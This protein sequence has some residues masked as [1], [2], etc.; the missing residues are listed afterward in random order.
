[1]VRSTSRNHSSRSC[2]SR[3]LRK[4]A[5]AALYSGERLAGTATTVVEKSRGVE[6]SPLIPA[7]GSTMAA[8]PKKNTPGG[9]DWKTSNMTS[10]FTHV[11][12]FDD[13]P[14]DRDDRGDVL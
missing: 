2:G 12:G 4:A 8:A 5:S 11:I 9:V 14:F 6:R 1:M 3:D 10:R 7:L 13:A